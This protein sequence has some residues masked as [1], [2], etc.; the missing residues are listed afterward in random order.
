MK[1][2]RKNRKW[3]QRKMKLVY[4]KIYTNPE[5]AKQRIKKSMKLW[6]NKLK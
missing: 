1:N 4:S 6:L 3:M 5:E 2:N